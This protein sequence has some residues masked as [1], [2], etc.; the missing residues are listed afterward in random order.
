MAS[1]SITGAP[2]RDADG[3]ITGAVTVSR[4]ITGQ[5]RLERERTEQAEQL[6]RIFEHIADGVVVYD[7][8]GHPVRLNAAARR[9]LGMDAAPSEYAKLSMSDRGILYHTRD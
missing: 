7:T 1:F 3:R 2:L 5:K 9:I 6:D 8:Q 4:D